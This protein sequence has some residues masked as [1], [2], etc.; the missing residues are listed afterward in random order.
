MSSDDQTLKKSLAKISYIRSPDKYSKGNSNTS[1]FPSTDNKVRTLAQIPIQGI[2]F[3]NCSTKSRSPFHVWIQYYVL[4][5][6]APALSNKKM[7]FTFRLCLVAPNNEKRLRRRKVKFFEALGQYI[8]NR[9][10]K[11]TQS[12]KRTKFN[13]IDLFVSL[14]KPKNSLLFFF[15]SFGFNSNFIFLSTYSI[16]S[17]S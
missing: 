13:E 15:P 7:P 9:S 5:L 11:L 17:F 16:F 12:S 14:I 2:N 1:K 8:R 4:L 3:Y 10:P 6:L